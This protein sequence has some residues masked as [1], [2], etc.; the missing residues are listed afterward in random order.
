MKVESAEESVEAF[1]RVVSGNLAIDDPKMEFV[2]VN[3]AAGI[4]LGGKAEDF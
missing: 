1:F 4:I 2:L 3:S